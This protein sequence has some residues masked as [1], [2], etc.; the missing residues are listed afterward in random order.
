MRIMRPIAAVLL[1]LVTYGGAVS[2]ATAAPRDEPFLDATDGRNWPAFGRLYGEQHYSPLTEINTTSVDK[3]KLAWSLD[4][5]NGLSVT[6]PVEVDGVIYF[7]SGLSIT[8]AVD[9]VLGKLLWVYDPKVAE[10]AAQK[11]RQGWGSRGIAYWNG[12]VFVGTL[13]G[14]LIAINA[15]TGNLV[16]S[17][18]TV[19]RNDVRYITG[20]PRVFDGKVI[21]GH[22]GADIGPM[23]GYV[24]TYDADTGKQLWRFYTVPGNPADGFENDA[25]AMAA[26]TWSGEWWKFGGGGSVWNA[27][28]YDAE[29]DTIM[30]GTGNGFPWNHK[31]RSLGH[32]DNLFICSIVAL[33]ARSG[34]Y[35][36]HYQY[37]PGESWDYNAAMDMELA[38]LHIG[39]RL[40]KV[41]MSAPKNGFFYVIDRTNGELLSAEPIVHVNWANRIDLNTGRPV[42]NPEARYPDG[43]SFTMW[44]GGA[45]GAHSW[46]PMAYSAQTGLVYIPTIDAA[47][48]YSDKGIDLAHWTPMG[49]QTINP[50]VNADL[51]ASAGA[52]SGSSSLLAWNPVTQKAVWRVPTPNV[53]SGGVLATGG[54]L[55]FQG[56]LDGT[57]NAYAAD[58]GRLLWRFNAQAPVMAPPITY[59]VGGRQY[60]TVLSG[61]GTGNA[62]FGPLL[63][64]M[65]I[66][67]RTQARRVLT[68]EIGGTATIPEAAPFRITYPPDPTFSPDPAAEARGAIIYDMHCLPCHGIGVVAQGNAPDLRASAVPQSPQAFVGIVH[69]G[70]LL[71][72]GMPRFAELSAPALDDLRQFL[73][74]RSRVERSAS[75]N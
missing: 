70:D 14:R 71:A 26:K 65:H 30:I 20:P 29:T 34:K 61:N 21:I 44:P 27:M 38:D 18:L 49:G 25:M 7:S 33:D 51:T 11:L 43:Q 50:G 72:R 59:S 6:G 67:Y 15:H 73:R 24:T 66:D 56:Q 55:V 19:D 1:A 69:G 23:R 41:V 53:I 64:D 5:G 48:T 36:W 13:D 17:A 62:S 4:L 8:H 74:A 35:K 12:K 57:F 45:L 31:I 68:F 63:G 2:D 22:G 10:A 42:E 40:R 54:N 9:A 52:S 3:L 58:D 39:G 46:L 75:G 47:V 60:V 16:W 28:T 32:G 37:N